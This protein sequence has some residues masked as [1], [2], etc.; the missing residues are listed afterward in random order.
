MASANKQH[1]RTQR[2]KAKAKQNR[3][4]RAS[5]PVELDP[6]DERIDFESVDLTELFIKMRD[7]EKTSQQALCTA[8]LEDPLLEIVFEQEGEE[9]ATDFILAA[10]IEYRQW[11]TE[12]DE[13]QALAW[14]ESPQ[15]QADYVAA[16]E[17]LVKSPR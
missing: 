10:L 3:V 9:G 16:S 15:F 5:A 14:I 11:S 1:K 13:A 4:Q 12:A 2:A 7:A 8:F 17:A 6:N